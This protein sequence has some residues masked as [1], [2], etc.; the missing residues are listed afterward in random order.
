[1]KWF[2]PNLITYPLRTLIYFP[3]TIFF[4]HSSIRIHP[5]SRTYPLYEYLLIT[6]FPPFLNFLT[7]LI[8]LRRNFHFRP[9][10]ILYFSAWNLL[11]SSISSSLSWPQ[12]RD[13]DKVSFS[14]PVSHLPRT[15]ALPPAPVC[16]YL[17][18]R[19]WWIRS[20]WIPNCS[21]LYI[22]LSI[23]LLAFNLNL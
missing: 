3:V 7:R 2:L 15:N 19:V 12:D 4:S 5:I 20:E 11:R 18:Y 22:I 23:I 6:F 21:V 14:T 9:S 16:W 10:H 13:F 17:Y 8:F 1:M